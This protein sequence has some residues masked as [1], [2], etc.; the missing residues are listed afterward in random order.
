MNCS[1]NSVVEK[2]YSPVTPYM[3]PTE[4]TQVTTEL[5]VIS[6]YIACTGLWVGACIMLKYH[7]RA[8]KYWKTLPFQS[9]LSSDV[10]VCG[11]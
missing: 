3:K 7:P 4:E 8:W 2:N 11:P 6:V 1:S 5:P 9:S 10:I